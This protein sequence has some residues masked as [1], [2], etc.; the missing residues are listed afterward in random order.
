[1]EQDKAATIYAE[2]VAEL[3]RE[4]E[5]DFKSKVKLALTNIA[6]TQAAKA[7][8]VKQFDKTITEQKEVLKGL[9][10]TPF[11]VDGALS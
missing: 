6:N 2:A 7:A 9:S 8:A 11:E 4:R 10:F 3:Q 1:M 5:A